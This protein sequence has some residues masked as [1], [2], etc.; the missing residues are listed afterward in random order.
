[1]KQYLT[2]SEFARLR[3][4]NIN[5]LRY[6][7][8]LGLLRPARVDPRTGYRYYLPEQLAQLDTILL[9]IDLG[10]P[11]K[12]LS[13]YVDGQGN[14]QSRR[15]LEDGRRL[16]QKRMEE[17][18]DGLKKIE[19]SLRSLDETRP[20]EDLQGLY[21]RRIEKR[22]LYTAAYTQDI[23]DAVRLEKTFS[24]LYAAAQKQGLSPL[25]PAGVLVDLERERPGFRLFCEVVGGAAV[26]GLVEIPAG[27]Y[28]C[29]QIDL[30]ADTDM[31][32]VIRQNFPAGTAAGPVI[33]ANMFLNKFRFDSKRTEIQWPAGPQGR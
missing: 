9:C 23:A 12:D 20:Y 18:R 29:L 30:Q 25:L 14:M 7:E 26:S 21:T 16:A 17:I 22:K 24:A 19:R 4:V 27:E 31:A 15:L 8:K 28:R 1:M 2:I 5:S 32:A 33:V 10:I 3:G 11:L 6:Y 13:G